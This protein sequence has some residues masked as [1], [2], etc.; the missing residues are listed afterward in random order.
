MTENDVT[1]C[2]QNR[3]ESKVQKNKDLFLCSVRILWVYGSKVLATNV[4]RSLDCWWRYGLWVRDS[5]FPMVT[6][7]TVLYVCA[8][9]TH[10]NQQGTTIGPIT[11]ISTWALNSSLLECNAYLKV[12]I[13]EK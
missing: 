3:H 2:I 8:K 4:F 12:C 1:L 10:K 11:Q 6:V 9:A 7:Q 5:I 13:P